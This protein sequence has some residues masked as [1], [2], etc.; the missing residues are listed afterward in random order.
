MP[1]DKLQN[2]KDYFTSCT[3]SELHELKSVIDL[4]IYLS[5]LCI[6]QGEEARND[7]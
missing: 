5:E 4:E 6:S 2:I 1:K 3:N 7:I